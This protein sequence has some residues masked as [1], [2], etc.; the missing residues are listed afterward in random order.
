MQDM[1]Q[2]RLLAVIGNPIK[3]S[4]SPLIHNY[5]LQKLGFNSFYTRFCL[6]QD[7]TPSDLASFILSSDLSGINV[8]LP[9]KETCFKMLDNIQGIANDI[10]AIN[11]IVHK[12]GKLVGYNTDA[13]GFYCAIKN[14]N[15]KHVL[16][17]GAGGSA[18]SIATILNKNNINLTIA[19]RSTE[20]LA[21]FSQ[22]GETL[23]FMDLKDRVQNY[24]IIVNATSASVNGMLPMQKELL[25]SLL[26]QSKLAYDL[27][28]QDGNTPFCALARHYTQALDGKA[29]LIYQGTLA[30]MYFHDMEIQDT[31]FTHITK[32]MA[33]ALNINL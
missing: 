26:Q 4:L 24:D 32:L 5:A 13:E 33:E 17:L 22:F 11:T 1:Q 27:M 23:G 15:P 28:Y 8:T 20:K 21:Y 16:L 12:N 29:M 18:R 19:N 30:L 14:H 7:I 2:L 3:H 10:G 25:I 6:P 31:Q 9:F